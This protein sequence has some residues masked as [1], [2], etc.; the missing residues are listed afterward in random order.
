MLIC[1]YASAAQDTSLFG[2]R[3]LGLSNS[4]SLAET[5]PSYGVNPGLAAYS[6]TYGGYG[7]PGYGFPYLGPALAPAPA[8]A[9]VPGFM[10]NM[11]FPLPAPAPAF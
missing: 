4:R 5:V 10:P 9:P 6:G 2:G 8:P 7:M 1:S 11:D 3:K